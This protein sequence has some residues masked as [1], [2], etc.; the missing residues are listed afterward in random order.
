ME[1]K[2]Q[3]FSIK[4]MQRDL[5]I[6]RFSPEFA[7]ENMNI[8]ITS[9]D[10]ETLMAV[11]NEKGNKKVIIKDI[12]SPTSSE[13][14]IEG[15]YL[16]YAVLNKTVV[17]FTVSND[18]SISYIYKIEIDED[19]NANNKVNNTALKGC[20]LYSGNLEFSKN[21]PIETI[22]YYETEDIQKIYWVD[23]KNQ[24]RFINI[25]TSKDV[26][27]NWTDATFDFLQKRE[28]I[29]TECTVERVLTPVTGMFPGGT[30]QY[31][32]TLF[33][34]YGQESNIVYTSPILYNSYEERGASP[35]EF[36]SMGFKINFPKFYSNTSTFTNIRI[37]SIIRTSLNATPTVKIVNDI[38]VPFPENKDEPIIIPSYIDTNL[39]GSIIDPS[40]LL[41]VGGKTIIPECISQKDN[42][43]FLGNYSTPSSLIPSKELITTIRDEFYN[44][45]TEN[46]IEYN[47]FAI[48]G[49]YNNR[50]VSYHK[51][52]N[53]SYLRKGNYYRLG[54]V[55]KTARG[56]SSSPVWVGDYLVKNPPKH[57]YKPSSDSS[58]IE[59]KVMVPHLEGKLSYQLINRI[60]EEGYTSVQPVIVYP[61]EADKGVL[62]QGVVCPTVFN[63]FERDQNTAF[64][65][66]SWFMRPLG[67][68]PIP[69]I[70]DNPTQELLYNSLTEN[71][72]G[73]PIE[74]RHYYQI[75]VANKWGGEIQN[76]VG[77]LDIT[78][79]AGKS[80]QDLHPQRFDTAMGDHPT[81]PNILYY[82]DNSILTF[83]SP[84]VQFN[85]RL[86][87]P[88]SLNN[89]K[90]SIVGAAFL[91]TCYYDFDIQVTGTIQG[92]QV[93]SSLAQQDIKPKIR[94]NY[95]SKAGKYSLAGLPLWKSKDYQDTFYM[96]Y[97]WH[98]ETAIHNRGSDA[99]EKFSILKN[100]KMSI[101]RHSFSNSYMQDPYYMGCN[102]I[103][104]FNNTEPVILRLPAPK[105]SDLPEDII[106]AGN[107]DKVLLASG[108]EDNKYGAYYCNKDT[109][110]GIAYKLDRNYG[111]NA[112]Y[113]S[114]INIKYKSTPHLVCVLDYIEK[115]LIDPLIP[116]SNVIPLPK[117]T[118]ASPNP[119]VKVTIND[120]ETA[121]KSKEGDS[122]FN[123]R[124]FWVGGP[125]G[126]YKGSIE[127]NQPSYL[128][129]T[130][131]TGINTNILLLVNITKE[132]NLNLLFGGNSELALR[133][134]TWVNCGEEKILVER[135]IP[136]P[137][138]SITYTEGDTYYQRFDC[139]KTYPYTLED[140]NSITDITSF[141]CETYINIEGRY[142]RNIGQK[143]NLVT[144]PAIFNLLNTAYSQKNNFFQ[145]KILD[146]SIFSNVRFPNSITWSRPKINA[147]YIDNWASI[148]LASNLDLDSDKGTLR[149]IKKFNNELFSFQDKGISKLL[150][151]S[152]V[153]IPTSEG[154]P[155]EIANSGKMD[156]KVYVT[157]DLGCQNKWSICTTPNGIYFI[158]NMNHSLY[159]FNGQGIDPV[160]DRLGF[161]TFFKDYINT[162]KWESINWK[163]FI[164]HYDVTNDDLYF[165]HKDKCLSFSETLN[166]FTSFYSYE[167]V[168]LMFSLD[169][170]FYS[171]KDNKI[172]MQEAGD[173]NSFFN[174]NKGYYS[175]V[176]ANQEASLDKII[177]NIDLRSDMYNGN[178]LISDKTFDYLKISNEYQKVEQDLNFLRNKPG[179]LQRKF[180]I[181]R[182]QIGRDSTVIQGRQSDRIRNTW[183][184]ITLGHKGE[185]KNRMVFYD[186]NLHYYV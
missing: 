49:V 145:Y 163:N 114:P 115:G 120:F 62:Y 180:R 21:F 155:I 56:E 130:S 136:S 182:I 76:I 20:K 72:Y 119:N 38:E 7:F 153:Q 101:L 127:I 128:D 173:Y 60:I 178:T 87:T 185:D 73:A 55:L 1:H 30:T 122:R 14:T 109:S 70:S 47:T 142:D 52:K 66:S 33:T 40:I 165:T 44:S 148:S 158:D 116:D 67:S 85:D 143:N 168:P 147:A 93:S 124:L 171:F 26:R 35:E 137:S 71:P 45:L 75:P 4:G 25:S 9:R 160:S 105:N 13:L 18:E 176:V 2:V 125:T 149:S 11:T 104:L 5:A 161:R 10:H 94:D 138:L 175:T 88:E 3:S 144:T 39:T 123:S 15:V 90:F 118:I 154:V 12:D 152:R 96:V 23:G 98:S 53:I 121:Y 6:S 170:K 19:P 181:W 103:R 91:D 134:N 27:K 174:V 167:Q 82:I 162:D 112:A 64:A 117:V 22:S 111:P 157:T 159:L 86:I 164:T 179:A 89:T 97:P 37:Y 74:G 131:T 113:D 41:Y 50:R 34:K 129:S 65:Q 110:L 186:M 177:T 43:L 32:I 102:T 78:K 54:L 51:A 150:F 79:D 77:E 169:G 184:K 100:K 42:H 107:V 92:Q 106:Y 59:N 31:A 36:V 156:G 83:H 166:Q 24:P 183:S 151:N 140:I 132:L 28:T 63:T 16:G 108:G 68:T 57:E 126:A 139:L 133:N 69:L 80:L 8:R 146:S 48:R 29:F 61:E 58:Y 141:M 99:E 84:D 95:Y 81:D 46:Y 172:W 135:E 17:I